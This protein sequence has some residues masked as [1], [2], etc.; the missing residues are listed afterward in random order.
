L[1][2]VYFIS[3]RHIIR[4]ENKNMKD[5]QTYL[6]SKSEYEDI[7]KGKNLLISVVT[8]GEE[9]IYASIR[10]EAARRCSGYEDAV[11]NGEN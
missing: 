9:P 1:F 7:K 5:I 8:K 4:K 11:F 3:E 2:D 10:S 6:V